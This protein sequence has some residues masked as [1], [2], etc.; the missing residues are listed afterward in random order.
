MKIYKTDI[1]IQEEDGTTSWDN[2]DTI[3]YDNKLWLVPTWLDSQSQGFAMPER[4]IRLD[5]L[6]PHPQIVGGKL[7]YLLQHSIPR[8]VLEG[9]CLPEDKL[10]EILEAPYI[11]V[12]SVDGAS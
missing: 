6:R 8:R 12:P 4:I 9:K 1:F 7:S 10:Y 2:A 3:E 11:L 5:S